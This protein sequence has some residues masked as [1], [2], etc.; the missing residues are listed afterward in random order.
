[1]I[2][3]ILKY[4]GTT[5]RTTCSLALSVLVYV[6]VGRISLFETLQWLAI[7]KKFRTKDDWL[8]IV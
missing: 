4:C 1:M 8:F 3:D 7:H 2:I 5:I 6:L